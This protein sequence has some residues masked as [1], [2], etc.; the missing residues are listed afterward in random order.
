MNYELEVIFTKRSK[1]VT[2][3]LI[4]SFKGLNPSIEFKIN[5]IDQAK[6]AQMRHLPKGIR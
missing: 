1:R 6:Y 3:E 4:K 2:D 5:V